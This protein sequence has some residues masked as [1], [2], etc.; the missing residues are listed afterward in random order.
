MQRLLRYVRLYLGALPHDS[1]YIGLRIPS[2]DDQFAAVGQKG[3]WLAFQNRSV[4][5][6]DTWPRIS[7]ITVPF[8]GI[9]P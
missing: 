4:G 7:M 9:R 3:I 6:I 1:G 2:C 5:I 8:C